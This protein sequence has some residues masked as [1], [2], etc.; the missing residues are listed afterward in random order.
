METLINPNQ[1]ADGG[2]TIIVNLDYM[3]D[4]T[5]SNP[6]EKQVWY[7]TANDKIYTYKNGQWVESHPSVGVWYKFND[8]YYLWDGNSLEETDLN[9]YEK[10]ANKVTNITSSSTDVQYPSAKAVY[11]FTKTKTIEATNTEVVLLLSE[12]TTYKCINPVTKLTL[13]VIPN[14][15]LMTT[16]YFTTDSSSFTFTATNLENKWYNITSPEFELGKE[17]VICISEGKAV[18]GKIGE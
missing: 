10:I 16:I 15:T 2:A 4:T 1:I 8:K 18:L 6:Q 17:Y 5:P 13:T 12:N 11:D 7:D 3:Q 9:I 14:S